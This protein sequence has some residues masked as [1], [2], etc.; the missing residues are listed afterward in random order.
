MMGNMHNN[1]VILINDI[2]PLVAWVQEN[3]I[4]C[5]VLL[6]YSQAFLKE[7]AIIP[8]H[9]CFYFLALSVF[10]NGVMKFYVDFCEIEKWMPLPCQ[11]QD[12][13]PLHEYMKILACS[14]VL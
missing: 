14:V 4:N 5:S 2:P 13:N 7:L 10:N 9:Y 8:T 3:M 6:K 1:L 12:S 11:S